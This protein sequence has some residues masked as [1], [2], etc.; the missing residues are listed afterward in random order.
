MDNVRVKAVYRSKCS[1]RVAVEFDPQVVCISFRRERYEIGIPRT[2]VIAHYAPAESEL[3]QLWTPLAPCVFCEGRE[4]RLGV[5]P[6]FNMDRAHVCMG[7]DFYA[8]RAAGVR[9]EDLRQDAISTALEFFGSDFNG[10]LYPQLKEFPRSLRS[11][12]AG[13]EPAN[14]F[15]RILS[16]WQQVTKELGLK[17]MLRWNWN[18]GNRGLTFGD[19]MREGGFRKEKYNSGDVKDDLL[20]LPAQ[21]PR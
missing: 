8:A 10:S 1:V 12:I 7:K 16:T 20:D 21:V 4:G 17:R 18:P 5:L 6:L 3:T 11:R 9:E 14:Y 13:A 15:A 2:Y 19:R